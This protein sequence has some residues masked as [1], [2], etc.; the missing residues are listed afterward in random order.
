MKKLTFRLLTALKFDIIDKDEAE[1]I[2][3]SPLP[4]FRIQTR[5]D[6]C[7]TKTQKI[8][9]EALTELA[10]QVGYLEA[11]T[12]WFRK[13]LVDDDSI[14]QLHC[15]MFK[16]MLFR[17]LIKTRVIRTAPKE[18]KLLKKIKQMKKGI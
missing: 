17:E 16:D 7:P 10:Q 12:E 11:L 5:T 6:V 1:D 9:I 4:E 2:L 18:N 14:Q 13:G 3:G 8:D 15:T